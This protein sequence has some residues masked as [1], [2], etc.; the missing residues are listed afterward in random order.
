M[1]LVTLSSFLRFSFYCSASCLFNASIFWPYSFSIALLRSWEPPA[2]AI[3][4]L[5]SSLAFSIDCS[6]SWI[7][8]A[9]VFLSNYPSSD[10]IASTL[11]LTADSNFS[12][13]SSELARLASSILYLAWTLS[14]A[15]WTY[16]CRFEGYSL[17]MLV[18]AELISVRLMSESAPKKCSS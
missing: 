4:L 9:Q 7:R 15:S 16:C 11:F 18:S 17:T 6:I 13:S 5:R 14:R 2:A 3:F 10:L 8:D 1:I 12:F